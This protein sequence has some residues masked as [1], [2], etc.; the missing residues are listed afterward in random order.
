MNHL[1]RHT[2]LVHPI[3]TVD[4]A[5]NQREQKYHPAAGARFLGKIV[6]VIIEHHHPV[7]SI[8]A[9]SNKTQQNAYYNV[10]FFHTFPSYVKT[11]VVENST[12]IRTVYQYFVS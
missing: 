4:T 8:D 11:L 5:G 9:A 7:N 6:G 2:H 3:N 1:Y 12:T 10:T